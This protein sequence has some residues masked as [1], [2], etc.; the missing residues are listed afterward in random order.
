MSIPFLKY[1]TGMAAGKVSP[2]PF[3]GDGASGHQCMTVPLN[4]D[5]RHPPGEAIAFMILDYI[6]VGGELVQPLPSEPAG[7]RFA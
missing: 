7:D 5:W 1:P 4:H 2:A 3:H 6:A